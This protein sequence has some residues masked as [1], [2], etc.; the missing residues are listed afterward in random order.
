MTGQKQKRPV[1]HC[2]TPIF[3]V[4]KLPARLF[5][6]AEVLSKLAESDTVTLDLD[7]DVMCP[8]CGKFISMEYLL[9]K[10]NKENIYSAEN[11]S[12]L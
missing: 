3:Y 9:E 6:I 1:I 4:S 12:T 11:K 8:D 2:N 10:L 5:D 7:L